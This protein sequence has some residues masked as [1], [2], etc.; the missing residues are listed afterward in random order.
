MEEYIGMDSACSS[1]PRSAPKTAGLVSSTVAETANIS[2]CICTYKRPHLLRR[3]LGELSA[4]DTGGLFKYS[5][6]V[7]DNDH[8]Q[9][10]KRLVSDFAALTSV[11][12]KYCV[13]PQ[14]SI[15]LA[16]NKA[17]ENVD[18]D[19]VAFIDDDE[20]PGKDWLLNL[21]K[22]SREYK[23]DGVLGPVKRHFDEKPPNW[24]AKS[25]F[26]ERP[27]YPT[28]FVLGW[29]QGRSGNLFLKSEMFTAPIQPFNPEFRTG[30]DQ[31]FLR[32]MMENGRVF[33]WCN[34]AVVFEVVP[35]I[36]WKRTFILKRAL[37]RGAM[38]P[39]VATFGVRDIARS[40]LAVPIY[41]VALPFALVL[42]QH[43]FMTLLVKLFDHV[44][45]LLALF[46]INPVTEEYV[47][48]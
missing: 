10:A 36:R 13:E 6:V 22:T 40:A 25:K 15:A 3:L 27:T 45:K 37:L 47:T 34:E 23:A 8:L 35:P 42:G 46:G 4:Q 44:G 11:P 31:D 17:V 1:F 21:L 43:R 18:G 9:S 5:I 14:Q 38:E 20:F 30:E 2:V 7:A 32:R 28:G 24:I 33:V 39:K 29:R 12:V 26:Y 41:V 19:F 48:D 16:R